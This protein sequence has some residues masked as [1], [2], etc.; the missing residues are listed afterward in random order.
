MHGNSEGVDEFTSAFLPISLVD[1]VHL[2]KYDVGVVFG[3]SK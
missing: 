2:R 3:K 1:F